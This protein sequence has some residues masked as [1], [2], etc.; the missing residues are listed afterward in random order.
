MCGIIGI[1]LDDTNLNAY[2]YILNG[3]NVLQHR[4]QDSAG[5][6]TC[7][8]HIFYSHKNNGKV[9]DVFH[10]NIDYSHKLIGNVGIGHVRYSTT[11][12]LNTDQCQPLYTNSPY[13]LA[14]V[15]NGNITNVIEINNI[16]KN[17][18]RH[19]NTNSD[20]EI[21]LNLFASHLNKLTI[22]I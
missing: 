7:K 14:L 13:G 12:S 19:V 10:T 11:G 1:Y 15:H 8:N 5:I 6:Y 3:L 4:G 21:L 16:I 9:N 2:P 20:S 17:E 22:F 18:K